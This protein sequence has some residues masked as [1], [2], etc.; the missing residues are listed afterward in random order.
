MDKRSFALLGAAAMATFLGGCQQKA[1]AA[2]AGSVKAAIQTDEKK[3]NEQFKAKDTEFDMIETL[4]GVGYR[5][6]ES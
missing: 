3:W 4:Y 6:K 1:Q 2:D 5:F